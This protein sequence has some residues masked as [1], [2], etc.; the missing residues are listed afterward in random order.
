MANCK[1]ATCD[2]YPCFQSMSPEE[3]LYDFAR[4]DAEYESNGLTE[5]DY[6]FI[7]SEQDKQ[8]ALLKAHDPAGMIDWDTFALGIDG[9]PI[10]VEQLRAG[11]AGKWEDEALRMLIA[12]DKGLP[13]EPRLQYCLKCGCPVKLTPIRPEPPIQI[14]KL[15]KPG[16][17]LW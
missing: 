9:L 12:A 17:E 8:I 15:K 2:R 3:R 13:Y 5:Q 14:K 16:V 7:Y 11:T 1:L 10:T 6:D 4:I